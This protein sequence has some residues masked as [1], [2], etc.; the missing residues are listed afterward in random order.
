MAKVLGSAVQ[1]NEVQRVMIERDITHAS[2][3]YGHVPEKD[4]SC[5][6]CV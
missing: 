2:Y 1:A 4:S 3:N 5:N 6:K